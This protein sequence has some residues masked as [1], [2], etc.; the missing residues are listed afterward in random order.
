MKNYQRLFGLMFINFGLIAISI[1]MLA[2]SDYVGLGVF[3]GLIAWWGFATTKAV[4]KATTRF[5]Q[6][7]YTLGGICGSLTGLFLSTLFGR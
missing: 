3:D 7:C 1:R 6:V 4:V 5:E 2:A